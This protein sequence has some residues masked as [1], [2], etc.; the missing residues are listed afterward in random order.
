M[1]V[2]HL[3]KFYPPHAGGVERHL[4]D[5][6]S[7]QAASGL[8]VAALVHASPRDGSR[9]AR[10]SDRG[11]LVDPVPCHGQFVFAPLS[12]GWPRHFHRLLRDFRP[13]LLHVHA[14]NP[15]AFWLLM[16]RAAK[17]LPWIVHWHADI[18]VDSTQVGLRIGYPVYRRFERMLNDRAYSIVTT[19]QAYL[20]ASRALA[21]VRGKCQ[22]VPLGLADASPV[23]RPAPT[24]PGTGLRLLAVG[25][26]SYYKGFDMLLDAVARC[27]QVS[28]L[29]VGAGEM[30]TKLQAQIAA[31]GLESRVRMAGKLDDAELDAA[32]RACDLFCLSS[33]DRAEAFGLVLLEAMRAGKPV[34]ASDIPG[35]G[36]GSVVVDG[37]TGALVPPRDA[38]AL[39]AALH[40]LAAAPELREKLGTAGRARWDQHY[41]IDAVTRQWTQLYREVLGQAAS[42]QPTA[43]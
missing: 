12:P 18:P 9:A 17:R 14:P 38:E 37:E 42:G 8:D 10:W 28:V 36:V 19:S 39:A 35:S 6:A 27:P 26:L 31:L 40:R 29:L 34:V 16:S 5:L 2:L 20:D 7:A 1:R 43:G 41:R 33:I 21:P 22:V 4:A 13:D 11:V 30:E 15:S 25:R 23:V 3:G 24:W 32:Y